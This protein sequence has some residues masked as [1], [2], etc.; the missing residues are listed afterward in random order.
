M[1]HELKPRGV[2]YILEMLLE[3]YKQKSVL[4]A[5]NGKTINGELYLQQVI[6]LKHANAEKRSEFATDV[7]KPIK[8]YLKNSGWEVLPPPLYSPSLVPSD[9]QLFRSMQNA[10][11]KIRFTSEQVIKLA[12]IFDHQKRQ[13]FE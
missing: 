10:L 11:S 13:H 6:K 1:P 5:K 12:T 9:H 7:T 8:S 3:R 2:G 4:I